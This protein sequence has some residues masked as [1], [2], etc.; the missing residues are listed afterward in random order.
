MHTAQCAHSM[1]I[2]VLQKM[3]TAGNL[4]DILPGYMMVTC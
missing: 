4:G 3:V 1:Y 2:E